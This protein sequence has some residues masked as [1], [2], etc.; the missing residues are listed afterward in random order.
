ML[1]TIGGPDG[2]VLLDRFDL[3][4]AA[5]VKQRLPPASTYA[6]II[7]CTNAFCIFTD[8][9]SRF[10]EPYNLNSDRKEALS[11]QPMSKVSGANVRR[12]LNLFLLNAGLKVCFFAR[13]PDCLSCPRLHCLHL[14]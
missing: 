2:L 9:M 10:Q 7:R 8:H 11:R 1:V 12:L 6:A 13:I 5:A 14:A 4:L 3:G